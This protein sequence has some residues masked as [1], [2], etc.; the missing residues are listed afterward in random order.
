MRETRQNRAIDP[1]D[2]T[3]GTCHL[4]KGDSMDACG[5]GRYFTK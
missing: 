4:A 2:V 1:A 5:E 3:D